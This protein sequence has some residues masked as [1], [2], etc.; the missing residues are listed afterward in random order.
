MWDYIESPYLIKWLVPW[1]SPI[2]WKYI[3]AYHFKYRISGETEVAPC[4]LDFPVQ[5][6][7]FKQAP[8]DFSVILE[9]FKKHFRVESPE[10]GDGGH[11]Q[12]AP[13]QAMRGVGEEGMSPAAERSALW[14]W[15]APATSIVACDILQLCPPVLTLLLNWYPPRPTEVPVP[16]WSLCIPLPHPVKDFFNFLII[17]W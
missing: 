10:M 5:T 11:P 7:L 12:P 14:P 2:M 3:L 6:H 15:N 1:H 8:W 4:L 13:S 17:S 16:A 9:E